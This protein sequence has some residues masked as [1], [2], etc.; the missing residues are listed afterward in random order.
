MEAGEGSLRQGARHVLQTLDAAI[1]VI[2]IDIGKNRPHVVGLDARDTMVLRTEDDDVAGSEHDL[3]RNMPPCLIGMEAYVVPVVSS[4]SCR[5][6]AT[7]P[8]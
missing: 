2:G 4:G 8:G 1:A 3:P 7:T 5:G 6:L